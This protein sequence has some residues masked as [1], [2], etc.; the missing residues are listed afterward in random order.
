MERLS[1]VRMRYFQQEN[2]D[3]VNLDECELIRSPFELSADY[4]VG[5]ALDFLAEASE[6]LLPEAEPNERHFRLLAA[7]LE[8]L[9]GRPDAV[10]LVV[11]Y[12][13]FWAVRLAGFLPELRVSR[14]S[15]EIAQEV[16]QAPIAQMARRDWKKETA[17]DLRRFLI[18]QME[19]HIERRLVTVPLLESL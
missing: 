10:W 12:F 8:H 16:A 7:V 19:E 3:L 6:Q 17:A 11:L 15:L 4:A 2:R 18:L 9:A 13:T 5:V 14:E 1:Q